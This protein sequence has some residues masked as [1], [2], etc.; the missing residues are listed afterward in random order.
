MTSSVARVVSVVTNPAGSSLR[1]EALAGHTVLQVEDAADFNEEGGSILLEDSTV[2][3]YTEADT[4]EDTLTLAA[5]L[6]VD[7]WVTGDPDGDNDYFISVYPG[8]TEMKAVV[9]FE[10]DNDEGLQAVV[11]L[12]LQGYFE[13]GIRDGQDR[14]AVTVDDE[15]GEW[16]VVEV[17]DEKALRGDRINPVGLPN[18][19]PVF[20]PLI[21][22]APTVYGTV[23]SL[24][25]TVD[26]QVVEPGTTVDYHISTAEDFN[27]DMTT[28]VLSTKQTVV[29]V[30]TLTDG[31]P[32]VLDTTYY[33]RTVAHNE[34]GT[35][36]QSTQT[37][38]MLDPSNVSQ[39]VAAQVVAGFV[40]AGSIQVGD[41]TINPED[42]IVIESPA[43]HTKLAADGSGNQFAG[44]G[45]FDAI[46]VLGNL[47]IYGI[48]N[49]LAGKLSINKGVTDPASMPILT[50]RYE[51]GPFAAGFLRRGLCK[52]INNVWITT[53]SVVDNGNIQG[54]T[55]DGNPAFVGADLPTGNVPVGGVTRIGNVFYALARAKNTNSYKIFRYDASALVGG[56]YPYLGA[57][58]VVLTGPTSY[59]MI[60]TDLSGNLLMAYTNTS[61]LNVRR[62]N[63]STFAVVGATYLHGAWSSTINIASIQEVVLG[64]STRIVASWDSAHYVF[65]IS[66]TNLVRQ[67]AQE[68]P[69]ASSGVSGLFHD[70]TTFTMMANA[71]GFWYYTNNSGTWDFAYSWFDSDSGGTGIA[72]TK[73]G[74]KRT[75]APTKYA[76]WV[77]SLPSA[78][79]DDG[80]TDGANTAKI[81]AAPSGSAL[82]CQTTLAEGVLS[83]TY[84]AM[85]TSGDAPKVVNEFSTRLGAVGDITS[86][87]S[88]GDGPLITLK[89]DGSGR[90]GPYIWGTQGIPAGGLP[91]RLSAVASVNHTGNST[92][93]TWQPTNSTS[94]AWVAFV[95]PPSGKVEVKI[96]AYIRPNA[97]G[98]GC[99]MDA[100]VRTGGSWGAGTVVRSPNTWTSVGNYNVNF[101]RAISH[102]FI[103]G[104]TPG[105]TY[106]ARTMYYQTAGSGHLISNSYMEVILR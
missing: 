29:V 34:A 102:D 67:T 104:L 66:G 46:N 64:G 10:D 45:V 40:L 95:A 71:S 21:S 80:T 48:T 15:T 75:I 8:S 83:A 88:D 84:T 50:S 35:A 56:K 42:G 59:P 1:E 55:F 58:G 90:V 26:N 105:Q 74:P 52:A 93:G 99:L 4:E 11:P 89:G 76:Q 25:I 43:G 53:D 63:P 57:S 24:V 73:P 2:L 41:I 3:T 82:V 30:N 91:A 87:E 96:G 94:G 81:Y 65:S 17:A 31:S 77:V 5:P 47:G 60:G 39:I 6:A 61:G 36:V 20:P 12:E 44:Q 16:R 33:V 37:A 38:G 101:I 85:A 86:V 23:D 72:E 49:F 100:E 14:E 7:V 68:W 92:T 106:H 78:P 22:P 13:E 98:N 103:E 51:R 62:L 18:P 79:P 9:V 54:W 97:D 69:R 28:L 70:G 27:A 32:L 19:V